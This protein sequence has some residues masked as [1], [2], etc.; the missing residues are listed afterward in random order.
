MGYTSQKTRIL[1]GLIAYS[2]T[3]I[4]SRKTPLIAMRRQLKNSL[5][6]IDK[7]ILHAI[8]PLTNCSG[9]YYAYT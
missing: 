1:T 8:A 4:L 7:L 9:F 5:T 6:Y 3:V 2:F